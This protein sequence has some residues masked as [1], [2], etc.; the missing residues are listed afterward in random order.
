MM[1]ARTRDR[2]Y[3]GGGAV[4]HGDGGVAL[5]ALAHEH[6]GEGLAHDVAA[7]YN[8][9]VLSGGADVVPAQQL[10]DAGGRSA[11][12]TG[13]ADGGTA[14][15]DGVEAVDVLFGRYGLDYGLLVDVARQG[16]LHY[17]AVDVGVVVEA[18]NLG[19]KR[20][21][22]QGLLGRAL[23]TYEG[24]CEA[25][26]L[27]GLHLRGHICLAASV[28]ANEYGGEVRALEVLGHALGHLGGYFFLDLC[29]RGLSVDKSHIIGVLWFIGA[30]ASA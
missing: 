30:C 16:E 11:V 8:H 21:R 14:H 25:A 23:E 4:A 26:L 6:G 2:G 12:E 10:D 19:Q 22:R 1:S 27:A 24:G 3:V 17:E 5:R 29:G 28:V 18:L 15:V 20:F 9:H 13:K 7:A